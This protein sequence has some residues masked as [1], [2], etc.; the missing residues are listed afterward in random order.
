MLLYYFSV[1]YSYLTTW[2]YIYINIF[3]SSCDDR[4]GL[5]TK[6]LPKKPARILRNTLDRLFQKV[7][8]HN[9]HVNK[10][11]QDPASADNS[12]DRDFQLKRKEVVICLVLQT[13]VCKYARNF[14]SI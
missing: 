8:L 3:I 1:S 7:L 13:V 9:N 10:L 11:M 14:Y 5:S 12:I 2:F 4:R 6:L